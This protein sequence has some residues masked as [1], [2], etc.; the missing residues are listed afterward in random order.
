MPVLTL[1]KISRM[2]SESR[3]KAFKSGKRRTKCHTIHTPKDKILEFL[4]KNEIHNKY[5]LKKKRGFG[6]PTCLAITLA[7]G[8]WD[9][10]MAQA[11]QEK[12][13]LVLPP[14]W[15]N[16]PDYFIKCV[17][18]FGLWTQKLYR[19][20]HA[21]YPDIIPSPS[22]VDIIKC[23]GSFSLL[24]VAAR[25]TSMKE[26]MKEYIRLK[27]KLKRKPTAYECRKHDVCYDEA[28]KLFSSK[29]AFVKFITDIERGMINEKPK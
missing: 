29:R 16:N 4:I 15:K 27:W 11:W 14:P 26:Q 6:D 17:L 18:E 3:K 23:W 28:A 7:F 21:K 22:G 12:P 8:T 1:E 20:A 25:R 10:A 13:G 24:V 2:D 9:E 19:E 5:Q